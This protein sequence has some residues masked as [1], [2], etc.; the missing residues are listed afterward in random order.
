MSDTNRWLCH[1]MFVCF[2]YIL[3]AANTNSFSRMFFSIECFC[4]KRKSA[5]SEGK[6]HHHIR[7]ST[8]EAGEEFI[9]KHQTGLRVTFSWLEINL[10]IPFLAVVTEKYCPWSYRNDLASSV[11]T[12]DL[13]HYFSITT[14]KK[15]YRV[16]DEML[17]MA[18]KYYPGWGVHRTP[19]LL[20]A[21]NFRTAGGCTP[22]TLWLFL[23][24][25]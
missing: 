15:D 18:G 13:G 10:I 17:A 11:I 4:A 1:F 6:T 21:H 19:P 23:T 7:E 5:A 2:V 8:S 25:S 14:A 16:I 3:P 20:L 24:F 12:N 22:E 9:D